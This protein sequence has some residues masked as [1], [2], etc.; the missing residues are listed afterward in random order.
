MLVDDACAPPLIDV[1][2]TEAEGGACVDDRA[3]DQELEMLMKQ[4]GSR[5]RVWSKMKDPD[6]TAPAAPVGEIEM[7]D[8]LAEAVK[9]E[10]SLP[11]AS[12]YKALGTKSKFGQS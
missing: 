5:K 3:L 8:L 6:H 7:D 2:S 9:A 10:L 4:G 11:S 1:S 12:D